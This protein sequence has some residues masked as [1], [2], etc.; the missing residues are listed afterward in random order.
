MAPSATPAISSRI[1]ANTA[2]FTITSAV[3][4]HSLPVTDPAGVLELYTVD[5]AT[6]S[7][8]ATL[9]RSGISLPNIRDL[10]TQNG[11]F[12]GVAAFSQAAVTLT[13]F[14]KPAPQAAFAVT[15]NYF[16]VLGVRP[17]AGRAFDASGPDLTGSPRAE[18]VLSYGLAE[19]LYDL[20]NAS[21]TIDLDAARTAFAEALSLQ[22]RERRLPW[23]RRARMKL[24]LRG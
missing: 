10:Q 17:V 16:D 12:N 21:R 9:N 8:L 5:H 7:S 2:I 22:T 15:A 23:R 1:G 3:F 14:G 19:R 4:L 24:R 20:A 13:G 18:T 6:Q 11:V